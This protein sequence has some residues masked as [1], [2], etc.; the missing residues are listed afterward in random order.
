MHHLLLK[1]TIH[2]KTRTN[3][4]L[5]LV[6][7]RVISWIV[8]LT[9]YGTNREWSSDESPSL[10]LRLTK[11]SNSNAERTSQREREHINPKSFLRRPAFKEV[12]HDGHSRHR[13]QPV[14]GREQPLLVSRN[15]T[16]VRSRRWSS[17][18]ETLCAG[19][20]VLHLGARKCMIGNLKVLA[21]CKLV[22]CKR[23]VLR[24]EEFGL[25]RWPWGF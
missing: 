17:S 5:L 4:K 7:F 13:R 8:F 23:E 18:S 19:A 15:S 16:G 10:I 2:E 6:P 14:P 9:M 11:R 3:T 20:G 22:V 25:L 24:C 1:R 12:L 21:A